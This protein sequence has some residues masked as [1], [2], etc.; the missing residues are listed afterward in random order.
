M[1]SCAGGTGQYSNQTLI[2]NDP[3]CSQPSSEF[4]RCDA[5]TGVYGDHTVPN[6]PRCGVPFPG[7]PT[8]QNP[9]PYGRPYECVPGTAQ[10]TYPDGSQVPGAGRCGTRCGEGPTS[11]EVQLQHYCEQNPEAPECAGR[12][13]AN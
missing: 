11:G 12:Q 1:L 7:E 3:N 8:N 6:D 13:S 4:L 5:K 2:P 10:C 9:D